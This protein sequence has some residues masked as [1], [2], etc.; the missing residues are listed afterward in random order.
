MANTLPRLLS[1]LATR[2]GPS[3]RPPTELRSIVYT[4]C[5]G[6]DLIT[7]PAWI[8][9]PPN[10]DTADHLATIC[11]SPC[12]AIYV[13]MDSVELHTTLDAAVSHSC[14]AVVACPS[15][16]HLV[17]CSTRGPSIITD[18]GC[19]AVTTGPAYRLSAVVIVGQRGE[20]GR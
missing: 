1:R 10:P 7:P 13:V 19:G 11:C 15:V 4:R 18:T 17:R 5:R 16:A 14:G 6:C 9:T 8:V 12:G 20:R 2:P 3:G